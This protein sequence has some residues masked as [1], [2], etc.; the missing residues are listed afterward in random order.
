MR[1]VVGIIA[2]LLVG[3]TNVEAASIALL[4][5]PSVLACC[6]KGGKHHCS[7]SIQGNPEDGG[8]YL[9]GASP[10]CPHRTLALIASTHFQFARLSALAHAPLQVYSPISPFAVVNYGSFDSSEVCD[11]GPPR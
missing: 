7:G 1:R 6:R 8:S 3:W 2:L 11:R 10:L 4:A 9:R 5:S